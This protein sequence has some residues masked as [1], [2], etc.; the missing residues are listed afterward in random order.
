MATNAEYPLALVIKAI[1]RASG[2]L[3]A[4]ASNIAKTAGGVRKGFGDL[5]KFAGFPK[6]VDGFKG[7]G[8]SVRS[9]WKEGSALAARFAA[10]GAVAGVALYGVVKSAVDAGDKL[11]EMADRVGL[12]V[13]VYASLQHAAG[14]ADIE[15]EAFNA[16]LDQFSKRLGEAKANGGPLLGFLRKVSPALAAQV[17]GA[18]STEEAFGLMTDAMA[19]IEDPSKRAA[20]ASAAFGKSGL[21]FGNFLHQGSAAIQAQQVEYLRLAGSQEKFA[22]SA[23]DVDNAIRRTET[24]FLGLRS[25]AAGALFPAIAKLAEAVTSFVTKNREGLEAWATRTSTAIQAW[26]DGGGIDRLVA[27]VRDIAST[28]GAAIEKIGGLENAVKLVAAAMSLNFA[29]SVVGLVGSLG[30]LAVQIALVTARLGGGAVMWMASWVQ[31][32]WMMRASILASLVPSLGAAAASVWAFTAALLANPITWVV[33]GVA[34]L[35]AA[36][37]LIYD[38]W[39]PIK[40]FFADL[41]DGITSRFQKA[42]DFIKTLVDK[43]GGVMGILTNPLSAAV[44]GGAFLAQNI[45]GDSGSSAPAVSAASARPAPLPA[46]SSEARVVVDFANAPKGTRVTA[47]RGNTAPLDLSVGYSMVTP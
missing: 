24:A 34:A 12:G 16:G 7:V 5:S 20:L 43:M 19:R 37:Y 22:R 9:V 29:S 40:E 1:D 2:P 31:Y 18:K 10:L 3:R 11:A 39:G 14:Q 38:N 42:W 6:L 28:V 44:K 15:Q 47:D 35:A 13:D 33:A 25:A 21:Q 27:G 41:W 32:L 46:Q 4:V 30:S 45:W 23:G 36:A 8:A 26:V 17:K